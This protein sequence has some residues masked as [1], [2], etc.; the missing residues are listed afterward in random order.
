MHMSDLPNGFTGFSKRDSALS[1]PGGHPRANAEAGLR[2]RCAGGCFSCR[3]VGLAL[4]CIACRRRREPHG[5]VWGA[6]PTISKIDMARYLADD[7]H[8]SVSFDPP[9]ACAD[10]PLRSTRGVDG[11]RPFPPYVATASR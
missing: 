8:G 1:P 10:L 4:G 5:G 11:D 2:L 6:P 7:A 3:S 9:E